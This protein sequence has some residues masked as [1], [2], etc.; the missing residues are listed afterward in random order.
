MVSVY[1]RIGES[2]EVGN[3][4]RVQY[5]FTL[6]LSEAIVSLASATVASV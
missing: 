4:R 2:L 3:F 1:K 5:V 6:V